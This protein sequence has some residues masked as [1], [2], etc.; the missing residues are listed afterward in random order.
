MRRPA[1]G[2]ALSAEQA[3]AADRGLKAM[4]PVGRPFLDYV[5]ASLAD[6][7]FTRI[8]LVIG[9]DHEPI[10]R[11]YAAQLRPTRFELR[12]AVQLEPRG[13]ADAVLAA[14]PV[15]AGEVFVTVNADNLYPVEALRALRALGGP[16]LIGYDPV[17]L[18]A[19]GNIEPDRIAR[20]ALIGTTPDGFLDWIIEKPDATRR[21]PSAE[22]RVPSISMN[23]WSFGPAIFTACRAIGPSP[24]NEY[25]LQDA[26][27][28]AISRLGERFRVLPWSGGV[29][30]LSSRADIGSVTERV[31]D[32]EVRL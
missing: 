24:R 9:P 20:F 28:F 7:G 21:V 3:A 19:R 10:R 1:T 13:T 4:I 2:V 25:E 29:I 8:C 30:D 32:L 26:V 23:S 31:R 27:T 11:R 16:G 17:A 14:E 18:V 5:L 22:C 15:T 6:A 12:F